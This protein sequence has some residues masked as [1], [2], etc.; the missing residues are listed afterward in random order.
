MAGLGS[1]AAEI[2]RF[3]AA[4]VGNTLATIGVYQ[5]AVGT[6]GPLGAY[7]ASWCVGIGLVVLLY[8]RFVFRQETNARRAGLLVFVYAAAFVIGIGVTALLSWLGVPE[9]LIVFVAAAVTSVF[10][11]L[12]ARLAMRA[13]PRASSHAWPQR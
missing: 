6:L 11:Y 4:G 3:L 2:A 13:S 12:S 8:P 9:R 1:L 7:V 5:L 10:S